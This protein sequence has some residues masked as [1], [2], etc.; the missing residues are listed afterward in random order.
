MALARGG[1]VLLLGMTFLLTAVTGGAAADTL[2]Y[3]CSPPVPATT[4][5]CAGWH[6]SA[7]SV[8]W[9]WDQGFFEAI[10]GDCDPQTFST[11]TSGTQVTCTIGEIGNHSNSVTG[12]VTIKVDMTPPTVLAATPD[13]PPDSN[14]WWTHPVVFTFTGT[15]ATSGIGSCD[16]LTYAGPDSWTASLTGVC[17]DVAGNSS[18]MT[19]P[20]KYDATPPSVGGAAA[21][22]GDASATITWHPSADVVRSEVTR[23][24]GETST[25]STRVFGGTTSSFK[26]VGLLNG[27]SYSYQITSFDDAGNS[28]SAITTV[29]P[30]AP[31]IPTAGGA[32]VRAT[33]PPLLTWRPI[34]RAGYYNLQL[35]RGRHKILSAW[36]ARAKLQLRKSWRFRGK[37]YRLKQGARYH[38]YVW[39]GYGT[40]AARRYGPL[41]RKGTFVYKP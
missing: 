13:R 40:R 24:P 34:K 4:A 30:A 23:T 38:W 33:A 35:F 6:T 36:P 2:D 28:S 15:D 31:P 22:P 16:Q 1:L 29:V 3:R 10:G 9:V 25:P 37:L 26:D 18:S 14:G 12:N 21:Q 7:I 19:I 41:I 5:A 32:T 8:H 17:R 11:D 27:V 20:L 39:P